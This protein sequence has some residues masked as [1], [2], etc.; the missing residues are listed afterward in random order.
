MISHS[1][2]SLTIAA[3]L[4]F[5]AIPIA[6]AQ[7]GGGGGS[8]GGSSGGASGSGTSGGGATSSGAPSAGTGGPTSTPSSTATGGAGSPQPPTG[9]MNPNSALG[10]AVT[11]PIIP[12]G[13]TGFGG[14]PVS[15]SSGVPRQSPGAAGSTGN[16]TGLGNI[17]PETEKEQRAQEQ[18]DKATKSICDRC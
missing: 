4:L 18:S 2:Q 16:Q 1:L 9:G 15:S 7:S 14:N 6:V 3:A 5:A 10:G 13:T 8:G 12:P 17:G 11:P